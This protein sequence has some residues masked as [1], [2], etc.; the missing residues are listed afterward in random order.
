MEESFFRES[1]KALFNKYATTEESVPPDNANK[2]FFPT[3]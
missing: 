2:T 1:V 3:I